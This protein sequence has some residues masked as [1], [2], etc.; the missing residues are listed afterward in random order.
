MRAN[1][2]P[3]IPLAR[4]GL[5]EGKR[6]APIYTCPLYPQRSELVLYSYCEPIQIRK[7]TIGVW[8]SDCE[9]RHCTTMKRPILT[10]FALGTLA[11]GVNADPN[12]ES[13]FVPWAPKH[14]KGAKGLEAEI[15]AL[16]KEIAQVKSTNA[17]LQ[18]Q[19]NLIASNPALQLGPF[20]SVDP[21]PENNVIGPNI[22]FKGANIHIESGSGAT[23]DNGAL[24]S[25]G[26]LFIGYNEASIGTRLYSTEWSENGVTQLDCWEIPSIQ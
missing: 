14:D 2:L 3:N 4:F 13:N 21:N 12:G 7:W 1:P 20:V 17:A 18:R 15:V 10:L 8:C 11:I 6:F 24:L 19:V 25:L 16:H 22:V 26:N 5:K 23:D 9:E